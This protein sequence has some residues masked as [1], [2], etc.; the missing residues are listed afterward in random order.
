MHQKEQR[1]VVRFLGSEGVKNIK[2]Q[3][4][5]KVEYGDVC[6]SLQQVYEWTWKFMNGIRSDEE[7]QQAVHKWLRLNQKKFFSRCIHALPKC[8]NTCME[9]NGDYI[10][11]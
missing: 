5:M 3:R 1:S 2:I 11:T 10:E 9:C 7:V 8:W 6:L 4:R